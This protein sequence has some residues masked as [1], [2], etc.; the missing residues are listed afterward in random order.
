[1]FQRAKQRRL[2]AAVLC[3][4]LMVLGL[5]TVA[6]S[7]SAAPVSTSRT[8]LCRDRSWFGGKHYCP[9]DV[10]GVLTT[11]YGTGRRVWL[12]RANV[13]GVDEH[14]VRLAWPLCDDLYGCN[15]FDFL[16]V[17][18]E[19]RHRPSTGIE[20]RLY[21]TTT[22]G[23]LTPAGYVNIGFCFWVQICGD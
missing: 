14:S 1:M 2:V 4:L 6:P 3:S 7:A 5:V 15:E 12:D 8:G 20:V 11:K 13:V 9:A 18:W 16:T 17:P 21:G 22:E 23:S 19:G 10:Q